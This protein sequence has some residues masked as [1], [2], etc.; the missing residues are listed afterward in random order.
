MKTARQAA[1]AVYD[2]CPRFAKLVGAPS[3]QHSEMCDRLTAAINSRDVEWKRVLRG[4]HSI[5]NPGRR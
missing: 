4:G 2:V 1:H 5:K 3:G